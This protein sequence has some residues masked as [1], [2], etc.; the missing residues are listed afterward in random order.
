MASL[1]SMSKPSASVAPS[2]A[3]SAM[4]GCDL[5]IRA[6]FGLWGAT[7]AERMISAKP[8]RRR[9]LSSLSKSAANVESPGSRASSQPIFQ[10]AYYLVMSE[11][12][13]G[14][15]REQDEIFWHLVR[16]QTPEEVIAAELNKNC[17]DLRRRG[18]ALGL[19]TKW[20]RSAKRTTAP[21][22][23]ESGDGRQSRI[24]ERFPKADRPV[25]PIQ[26]SRPND[27]MTVGSRVIVAYSTGSKLKWRR[28]LIVGLGTTRTRVRVLLDGNM[29]PMTLHVC[30]LEVEEAQRS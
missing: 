9:S 24:A 22:V 23:P 20:F 6:A 28:G 17:Q 2:F 26:F 15:T 4:T 29:R 13:D 27:A 14:W 11:T 1:I 3:N 30:L 8:Y 19:P 10:R 16:K 18:Y 25:E 12:S 21:P 7:A 5:R